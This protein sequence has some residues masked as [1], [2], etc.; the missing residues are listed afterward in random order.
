[1]LGRHL[2]WVIV[3]L[4]TAA[5]QKGQA[6]L[7]VPRDSSEVTMRLDSV[8]F[9][10][11]IVSGRKNPVTL[12][13]DTLIFDVSSFFVP[14]GAK[15]RELLERIPGIEVTA[16]GRILAQ[17]KEVIRIKMNGRNFFE[18][19]LD[20]A[21]N[22]LPA[23][24]LYEVKLYKELPDEEK[25][26]GLHRSEGDQVLDVYTRPERSTGWL[27]DVMGAGGSRKRY[28][29]GATASGYSSKMQGMASYTADNQPPVFGIGESY[30]DKLSAEANV[31]EV[32]QQAFNGIFNMFR[33]KW[34]LNATAF[35]NKNK[36]EAASENRTEYYWHSPKT[37]AVGED[38]RRTDSRSANGALDWNYTGD[39]FSWNTKTYLDY[40][41][42]DHSLYSVT[43][44]REVWSD[45]EGN[46]K[47]GLYHPLNSNEYL[48][49]GGLSS[50]G[51]GINTTLNKP[52][53]GRGSNVEL[54]A[55]IHYTRHHENGSAHSTVYFSNTAEMSRQV[56][57]TLSEKRGVRGVL[58]GIL[59]TAIGEDFK[60][61]LSYHAERQY[62][63]VDETVHDLSYNFLNLVPAQQNV[64]VDSLDKQ[65]DLTTWIH[66][67]R[68]LLQYEHGGLRL[69]G[70]L[71]FEPQKMMLHYVKTGLQTDS[72]QTTFSVL[73]EFSMTYA[74]ADR[75]NMSI[76]YM[77]RCKQPDLA[78][79][80]PIWDCTDPLHR[81]VGNAALRPEINHIFSATF[82]SFEPV[83]Q[84]Q[85][86]VSANAALNR[87]TISQRTDFD[88]KTG[89]YTVMP[90]NVDG[91][92]N[93]S[94]IWEFSTSF[95]N[96]RRWNLEWK[97][98]VNGGV[99]QALQ[100][101]DTELENDGQNVVARISSLTTTHYGALQYKYRSLLLKPYAFATWV[102]YRNNQLKDMNSELWIYGW[103]GIFRLDFDFGLSFGIDFYRNS[104]SGYWNQDMNGHEWICNVE[105][106]YAFLKKKALEVKV[107]GFD[108]LHE[109]RTVNQTNTV[110][111]RRETIE[112]K[113]INSYFLVS[114]AYHFDCFPT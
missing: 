10:E 26:T 24:I 19:G 9:R 114:L 84:R 113:G 1:M 23:D 38:S 104:R 45:E 56:L 18:E 67:A 111:F 73:P 27:L 28:Q 92:W 74:K 16:D 25:T 81:Y 4:F 70:G 29:A 66:E 65:A 93:A 17:G 35:L 68:A 87:R 98:V 50:L 43:E 72:V 40:S 54:S 103:G 14:E 11:L 61:Q 89:A 52:F 110:S 31:N 69:T 7:R 12:R 80:L 102:R 3:L 91:D 78:G 86:N 59:T 57:E 37:Y 42:H 77:G 109:V 22:H 13:G 82:F 100:A 79:M 60:L 48:N 30:V 90:V 8:F 62:D 99:E 20:M 49:N 88:A 58:K 101:I 106:S 108:L 47:K 107:Q 33:G 21:L 97:S 63:D 32:K 64:P 44:T 53:G 75:W 96:A 2:L 5:V 41:E 34:E 36:A 85:I 15:L 112:H 71:T 105:L 55:G 95:R 83:A 94:C 46:Q 76:R 39:S 6:V 51:T